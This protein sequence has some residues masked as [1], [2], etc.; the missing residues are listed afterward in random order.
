[1]KNRRERASSSKSGDNLQVC[2]L[3]PKESCCGRLV[4]TSFTTDLVWCI[5]WRCE[6]D[7]SLPP[8]RRSHGSDSGSGLVT[9]TFTHRD[10]S[11]V[12]VPVF[13]S[14]MI[15]YSHRSGTQS[16][17]IQH[18]LVLQNPPMWSPT[19][20]S[21]VKLPLPLSSNKNTG[22]KIKTKLQHE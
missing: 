10:I 11:P 4:C 3:L 5:Q 1:M 21:P 2:P 15:S 13:N 14:Q 16:L 8:S 19:T 18:H 12:H 7:G 9:S 17:S 20:P 22:G 6:E